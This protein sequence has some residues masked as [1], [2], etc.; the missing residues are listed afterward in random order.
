M[1]VLFQQTMQALS[2]RGVEKAHQLWEG[3]ILINRGY[4]RIHRDMATILGQKQAAS[5]ASDELYNP[6]QVLRAVALLWIAHAFMRMA[7]HCANICER[8]VFIVEGETDMQ[9][10]MDE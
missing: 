10:D 5:D 4:Y 2:E 1:Q 9:P 6:A 8:I 7:A 3:D